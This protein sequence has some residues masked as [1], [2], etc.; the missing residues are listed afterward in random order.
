VADSSDAEI[1]AFLNQ[2]RGEDG[3]HHEIFVPDIAYFIAILG[4]FYMKG[5][6]T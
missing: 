6:K 3:W 5:V 2:L 4:T 1:S